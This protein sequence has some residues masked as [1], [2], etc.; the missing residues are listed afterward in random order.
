LNDS[1]DL[2]IAEGTLRAITERL[3]VEWMGG[4]AI[5]ASRAMLMLAAFRRA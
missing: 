4:R 2:E 3:D 5:A 1:R